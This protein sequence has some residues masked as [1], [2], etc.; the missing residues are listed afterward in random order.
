MKEIKDLIVY[1]SEIDTM[2]RRLDNEQKEQL[3]EI[4][5]TIL[6]LLVALR[7]SSHLGEMSINFRS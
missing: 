3:R 1:L 7:K 5:R 2:Q 6:V 4:I